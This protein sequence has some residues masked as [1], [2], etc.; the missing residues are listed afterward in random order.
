[1]TIRT[2]A[3]RREARA[4]RKALDAA[5]RIEAAKKAEDV[6]EA[7]QEG[8]SPAMQRKALTGADG[9]VI[10]APLAQPFG[11]AFK[12]SSALCHL[13]L[14]QPA[15]TKAHITAADR[16]QRA[17]EDGG[18]GVGMPGSKWETSYGKAS[19]G[20]ISAGVLA[21][22]DR[23]TRARDEY[24]AAAKWLGSGWAVIHGVVIEGMDV[25][26]WTARH[27]PDLDRKMV[28]GMLIAGLD[29]LCE[30]YRKDGKP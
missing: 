1:M 16:L 27:R 10:R 18:R 26:A 23:Q 24:V 4:S 25:S 2:A 30:L 21:S 5:R 20:M 14:R 7:R 13:A 15:I 19:P 9:Q 29:R 6:E 11:T 12:R 8:I 3:D 17:W 22:I 28:V